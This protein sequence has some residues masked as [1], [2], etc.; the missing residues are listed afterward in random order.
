MFLE[1]E[2]KPVY[3]VR[4]RVDPIPCLF[5]NLAEKAK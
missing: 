3:S 1:Y 4:R 5:H 2:L